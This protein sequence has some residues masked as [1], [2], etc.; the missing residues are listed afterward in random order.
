M[1]DVTIDHA[2]V[3][4]ALPPVVWSQLSNP[5][6]NP[7]WQVNCSGITYLT[8]MQRGRGARWRHNQD[9]GKDYVVEITAWY[10]GLGY[11]YTI[12]DGP[13]YAGQNRGR[14]RLQEVAEG[15]VVQWTFSYDKRGVGGG[16]KRKINKQIINSLRELY[17]HVKEHGADNP[18]RLQDVKSFMQDA[19]D[20][21]QRSS[22]KPRYPSA[23]Q[24]RIDR[25]SG[26]TPEPQRPVTQAPERMD[27]DASYKP[28][29]GQAPAQIIPEPP[30]ADDDTQPNPTTSTAT[31][32]KPVNP[33]R[34]YA[35]EQSTP[36]IDASDDPDAAYRPPSER[37]LPTLDEPSFLRDVPE[38]KR[39]QRRAQPERPSLLDDTD[40]HAVVRPP[41]REPIQPEPPVSSL[42]DTGQSAPVQPS[43]PAPDLQPSTDL[44]DT[45]ENPV[46]RPP[47][48]PE[49]A[50]T[51]DRAPYREPD[52]QHEQRWQPP[53]QIEPERPGMEPS[54]PAAQQSIPGIDV[55]KD[56]TDTSQISVFEIFGLQKPSET[57]QMRSITPEQEAQA[58]ADNQT[59]EAPAVVAPSLLDA[60]I[61]PD[62]EPEAPRREGL[63]I[64]KRRRQV[65]LR[66]PTD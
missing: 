45:N 54:K 8:S 9:D 47:Q 60:A 26:N 6:N 20:V 56:L 48:T 41:E 44:A 49:A 19:P 5:N 53:T 51:Q 3:I 50:P 38:I 58:A 24:Q 65:R 52:R 12:V 18:V 1:A 29:T 22:Y 37:K 15:T 57:Q 40:Q 13:R 21:Q 28:S 2:I 14:I 33:D 42:D 61:M 35:P 31:E 17:K 64:R 4:P 59:P 23:Y 25:E 7:F 16:H 11:E 10:E 46:V 36:D 32:L 30:V 27:A 43:T 66:R 39:P 62:V 63:R 55:D 34:P